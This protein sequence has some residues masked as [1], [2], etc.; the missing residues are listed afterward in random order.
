M[1]TKYED[2][3]TLL[4]IAAWKGRL[5]ICKY[6]V[7][8]GVDARAQDKYGNTPLHRAAYRGHLEVCKW[9]V[10]KGAD[11]NARD[12]RF[13]TPLDHARIKKNENEEVMAY[14]FDLW[15]KGQT[16]GPMGLFFLSVAW[17][18]ET[19]MK[20]VANRGGGS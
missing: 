16:I 18:I 2:G 10:S 12:N 11:V 5:D 20:E 17:N 8:G 6:L 1:E 13:R 14:L 4:H 15:E 3:R 9:L 19:C 7:S